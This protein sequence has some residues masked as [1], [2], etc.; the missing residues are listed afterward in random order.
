MGVQLLYAGKYGKAFDCLL[1]SHD[2]Y[3][4]HPGFWLRLAECCVNMYQQVTKYSCAFDFVAPFLSQSDT[5][6]SRLLIRH[7]SR[8]RICK[9]KVFITDRACKR[10]PT[11][12]QNYS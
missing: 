10:C 9:S 2:L 4:C 8:K 1:E 6:H 11:T 12:Y 7:E 3:Q 5:R